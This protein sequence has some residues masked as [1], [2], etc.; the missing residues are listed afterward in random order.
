MNRVIF[1]REGM[2]MALL[3]DSVYSPGGKFTPTGPGAYAF[4][5]YRNYDGQGNKFGEISVQATSSDQD[6]LAVYAATRAA[7][8]AVTL[9]V[10]NKTAASLTANLFVASLATEGRVLAGTAQSYRYSSANLNAIVK[11]ADQPVGESSFTATFPA[12][13]ITLIVLPTIFVSEGVPA[14]PA[15]RI[16]L[17]AIQQ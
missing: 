7:D 17:P 11:G 10:I 8:K 6:K 13:S 12:N 16:Y 1:G 14:T 2:D 5:I 9:V 3:F 15:A 4:R